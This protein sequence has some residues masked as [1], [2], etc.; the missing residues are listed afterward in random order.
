MMRSWSED[1]DYA[2]P[3]VLSPLVE[4]IQSERTS[5]LG[6][7]LGRVG[8]GP[9]PGPANWVNENW[10]LYKFKMQSETQ[11]KRA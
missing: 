6:V 9:G 10:H 2:L 4:Y 11:K 7:V 3:V 1:C 8:P 5:F